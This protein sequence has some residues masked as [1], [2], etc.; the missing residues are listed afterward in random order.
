MITKTFP[1]VKII[2]LNINPYYENNANP[3]NP[4]D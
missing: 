2:T 3:F 4:I 1:N